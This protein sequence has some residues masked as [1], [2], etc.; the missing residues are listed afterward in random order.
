LKSK[1]RYIE[2]IIRR[3]RKMA[4]FNKK[5]SLDEILKA[6]EGLSEEEKAQVKSKMEEGAPAEENIEQPKEEVSEAQTEEPKGEEVPSEP[7]QVETGEEETPP[8]EEAPEGVAQPN[9]ELDTNGEVPPET[10]ELNGVE[11][12]NKEEVISGLVERITALEEKLAQ[13]EELKGLMEQFT[14]KQADSFGYKG[15]I[16]GAKKDIHEMSASELKEKM[17][18]GEI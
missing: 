4:L 18:N 14:K 9:E 11:Q 2:K 10:E 16:P 13:F 17:L 7:E 8:M 3:K 6:I 5:L 15:A 12:D 1:K